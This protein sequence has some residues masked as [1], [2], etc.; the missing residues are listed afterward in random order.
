M[1]IYPDDHALAYKALLRLH[2][3]PVFWAPA[4]YKSLDKEDRRS[5]FLTPNIGNSSTRGQMIG[6]GFFWAINRSY[7][8]MYRPQYYTVRGFAHTVDFAGRPNERSTDTLP[9]STTV[10]SA[11][12]LPRFPLGNS[13]RRSLHRSTPSGTP[14]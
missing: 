8:M 12:W 14:S 11:D 6:V 3:I 1:V 10:I 7:Q 5:G 13:R 2:G 4:F 9:L